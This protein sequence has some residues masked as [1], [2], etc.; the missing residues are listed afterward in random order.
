M[1]H[2]SDYDVITQTEPSA[3]PSVN[4][5]PDR[6]PRVSR[7][8]A[9]RNKRNL[10]ASGG[11]KEKQKLFAWCRWPSWQG[12]FD[13]HSTRLH[14]AHNYFQQERTKTAKKF[15]LGPGQSFSQQNQNET[16]DL[17]VTRPSPLKPSQEGVVAPWLAGR[18][19]L[20]AAL[21]QLSLGASLHTCNR[22]SEST[23]IN[24]KGYSEGGWREKLRNLEKLKKS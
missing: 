8:S 9:M 4:H 22:W 3:P 10:Q 14:N 15:Q 17:A 16:P 6:G 5:F 21:A 7:A 18:G 11:W 20:Q 1:S 13:G 12:T 19:T 24:T 2:T 23:A